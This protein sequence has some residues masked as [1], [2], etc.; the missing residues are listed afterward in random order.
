MLWTALL[1][2]P[3][4]RK[5][6]IYAIIALILAASVAS[7]KIQVTALKAERDTAN[8]KIGALETESNQLRSALEMAKLQQEAANKA[9]ANR[10]IEQTKIEAVKHESTKQNIIILSKPDNKP[11]ADTRLT[12]DMLNIMRDK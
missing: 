2:N 7:W 10:V 11:L 12:D 1:T 4:V 3:L 9:Q 5:F 8:Q 6:G